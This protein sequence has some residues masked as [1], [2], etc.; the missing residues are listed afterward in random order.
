[1]AAAFLVVI[2]VGV[3]WLLMSR[4]PFQHADYGDPVAEPEDVGHEFEVNALARPLTIHQLIDYSELVIVGTPTDRYVRRFKDAVSDSELPVHERSDPI[5]LEGSF[6]QYEVNVHEM[7]K[8]GDVT[9][10]DHIEV[11]TYA[12]TPGVSIAGSYYPELKLGQTYL[13]ILFRGEGVWQT[14]WLITGAEGLALVEGNKATFPSSQV[15]ALADLR[16]MVGVP[17]PPDPHDTEHP[18]E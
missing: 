5:Y 14:R 7:L 2:I 12:N 16:E 13:F 10:Q 1:M 15:Y 17:A 3:V 9:S 18:T 8:G 4:L 6:A 11:R